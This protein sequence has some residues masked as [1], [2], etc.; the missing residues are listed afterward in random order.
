MTL[1]LSS[2]ACSTLLLFTPS[3][4][5]R[6]C[7]TTHNS[8]RGA[9]FESTIDSQGSIASK[10]SQRKPRSNGNSSQGN[11]NDVSFIEKNAHQASDASRRLTEDQVQCAARRMLLDNT[12]HVGARF[13]ARKYSGRER[14]YC[15]C[16]EIW[17]YSVTK[18][19]RTTH[20]SDGAMLSTS[21][22]RT[23]CT[24]TSP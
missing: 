22:S 6:G 20:R 7:S 8:G 21:P 14:R 5:F 12:K 9:L 24:Y 13:G 15:T 4:R 16:R 10:S 11:S 19:A 23:W 17:M 3:V 2:T 18:R 1:P